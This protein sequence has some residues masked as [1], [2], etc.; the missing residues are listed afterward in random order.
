[1]TV[2]ALSGLC[3]A[4][5]GVGIKAAVAAGVS[6]PVVVLARTLGGV[7]L[8]CAVLVASGVSVLGTNRKALLVRGLVGCGGVIGV[9]VG[10]AKLPLAVMSLTNYISPIVT[11]L[12]AAAVLGEKVPRSVVLATQPVILGVLLVLRPWEST[13]SGG[14]DPVGVFAALLAPVCIGCAGVLVRQLTTAGTPEHPQVV[15]LYLSVVTTAVVTLHYVVTAGALPPL[16]SALAPDA[17]LPL[18]VVAVA[19]WLTQ[20]CLTVGLTRAPAA[21]A[22]MTAYTGVLFTA[23]A[24]FLIYNITLPPL[25]LA[26]GAVIIAGTAAVALDRGKA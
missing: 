8:A 12:A 3:A 10:S 6:M 1:M 5:M 7:F 18:L 16:A 20:L 11:S 21:K 24:D 25:A 17:V 2:Y 26:G 4:V 13:A 9:M 23:A 15:M 22:S 19:G 14:L